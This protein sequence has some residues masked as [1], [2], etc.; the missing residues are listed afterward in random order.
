MHAPPDTKNETS[1][2]SNSALILAT[3]TL[4]TSAMLPRVSTR[5][6]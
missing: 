4:I 2:T 5:Q 6:A 3:M 1:K